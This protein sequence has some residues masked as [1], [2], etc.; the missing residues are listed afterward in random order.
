MAYNYDIS[1]L[2]AMQAVLMPTERMPETPVIKGH[3][4]NKGNDLDSIMQS[5][6]TTGFQ[7]TAVGQAVNEINR[8]INWRLSDEPITPETDPD[9]LDPEFRANTR[10]RIFLGYTSNLVSAGTREQIRY[11]V[12]HRMVDALVTTAG[13]VEEDFIKCL[14]DT[15]MGDF[16]LKGSELR[17]Q[18]LNRIGN[19]LVPN[20][21]YVKFEEWIMPILDEMH[22]EQTENGVSWTPSKIIARLGQEINNPESIAYWAWKNDIPI[23][24]PPLT[25]GSIGD[26]LFFHSYKKQYPAPIRCDIVEDLKR[27]NDFAMRAFP[28]RTGMI[29][30]GGGVPKHHICNANLMRN[31]ADFS[32]FVNTAQEFD[33]CDS[34]AR[35]DE[36]ISWGK[37]KIDA[38]PVK[39]Y[40]DATVILPLLLSQTFAKHWKPKEKDVSVPV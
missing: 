29:I 28:R 6:L 11:L 27:I 2:P 9:H 33:G 7:A 14:A 5:M 40:A 39:V 25:D 19:M 3:D 31:G 20:S 21:N 32:V 22:K 26:M 17:M 15:Y 30:L 37:I 8:M 38:Q 13:G 4:F 10:T 36:A 34:G 1:K 35:P 23:F 12:E 18:G 16:S 24:C